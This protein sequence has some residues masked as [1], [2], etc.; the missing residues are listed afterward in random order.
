MIETPA[1]ARPKPG[2]G[3]LAF[4]LAADLAIGSAVGFGV[5]F[6]T[7]TFGPPTPPRNVQA[8]AALCLLE[9]CDEI[10]A[11]VALR[12]DPPA[13][14]SAVTAYVIRRDGE[15]IGRLGASE[16][17][18]TDDEVVIDGDYGY[19][20]TAIGVEGRGRPSPVVDVKVPIPPIEQAHFSGSYSVQLVFKRIGLLSRFEGVPNPAVGD[21]TTQE[22]D[23]LSVCAPLEGAC[24]VALFGSE[25]TQHGRDYRGTV[26]SEA[27]CGREHLRS[28]ETVTLRVTDVK[29]FGSVLIATAFTG[30]S[31]VDFRC[32]G[33]DVH[34]VASISGT[35]A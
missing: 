27:T 7:R 4:V 23:L 15:E 13:G 24:D 6:A 26:P 34:A 12:W 29:V 2:R 22:W 19:D 28:K 14:G 30:T 25:L 1:P 10:A 16:H 17:G 18:Y 5:Y 20:V 35:R 11:T 21:R 33:D 31:V 32:G 3:A 8:S 9:D